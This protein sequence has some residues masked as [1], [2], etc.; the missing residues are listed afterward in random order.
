M[1]TWQD[2]SVASLPARSIR[3]HRE[4]QPRQDY[5]RLSTG[6]RIIAA[7]EDPAGLGASER[8]RTRIHHVQTG[9]RS[10]DIASLMHGALA[11]TG[12]LLTRLL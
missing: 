4:P 7:A 8:L 2:P 9:E 3:S 10:A 6:L 12:S 11:A 1:D 5:R